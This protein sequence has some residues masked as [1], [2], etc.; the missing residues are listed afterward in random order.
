MLA[1]TF[2]VAALVLAAFIK[3]STQLTIGAG[4]A[5]VVGVIL[6]FVANKQIK[7]LRHEYRYEDDAGLL[8]R[9]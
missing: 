8:P 3:P 4:V 2:A 7:V 6:V 5:V 1:I 9:D